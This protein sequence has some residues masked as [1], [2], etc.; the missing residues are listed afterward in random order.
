[1]IIKLVCVEGWRGEMEGDVERGKVSRALI[2][3]ETKSGG[4]TCQAGPGESKVRW[5]YFELYFQI[6]HNLRHIG[7]NPSKSAA[8]DVKKWII[9]PRP[10]AALILER[11]RV[12]IARFAST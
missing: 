12:L 8:A 6:S 4:N 1:M 10:S 2:T 9:L 5:Y 11:S 7:K 3:P